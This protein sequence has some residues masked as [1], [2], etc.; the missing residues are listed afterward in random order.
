VTRIIPS[1]IFGHLPTG[2][3]PKR[4]HGS[5]SQPNPNEAEPRQLQEDRNPASPP[6]PSRIISASPSFSSVPAETYIPPAKR[7]KKAIAEDIK[8]EESQ[9][10]K[11]KKP[12]HSSKKATKW[13]QSFD[14]L[15]A[16]KEEYGDCVVPRGY[17]P[18]PRLASWVAEQRKQYK[19]LQDGKPSSITSER[20]QRLNSLDFAWNA[21]CTAWNRHM[22]A[23]RNYKN[24]YGDCLVPLG[25]P[26]YPK[27]GLWVKEQRRH[28]ALMKAGKRTH[29]TKERAQALEGIGF[30][31]DTHEAVWGER[32]KELRQYNEVHGDCLVPTSYKKHPKL[33]TWVHHQ[34]RQF[35][36]FKDG[37]SC[38]ITSERIRILDKLGFTWHP[39]K[40]RRKP[41]GKSKRPNQSKKQAANKQKGRSNSFTYSSSDEIDDSSSG[42][43][44]E[45]NHGTM[46][47]S[48][49]DSEESI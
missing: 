23:L 8:P 42:S 13:M 10:P 41:E 2:A 38:H 6:P 1:T 15:V 19:L 16:Y 36:K 21:Q 5:Q 17:N 27:L 40:H 24:D 22:K 3:Q 48:E 11:V 49:T 20:I 14:Q 31:W 9:P 43:E 7:A 26:E 34:R 12:P 30:C 25:H 39:R 47:D 32:Y 28:F 45:P 29:M 35:K 33:S 46:S 44:S 4:V 37:Q 18:N